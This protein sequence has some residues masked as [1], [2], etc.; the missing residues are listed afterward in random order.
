KTRAV[1][2]I[3]GDTIVVPVK[4][5]EKVSSNMELM[6]GLTSPRQSK[7]LEDAQ[8]GVPESRSP[9]RI[10]A[11]VTVAKAVR[12]RRARTGQRDE[13]LSADERTGK[14]PQVMSNGV[15]IENPA[16]NKIGSIGS[17]AVPVRIH[18]GQNAERLSRLVSHDPRE[19]KPTERRV[20]KM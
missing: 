17:L 15:H 8:I 19:L 5:V 4:R 3:D 6:P 9:K 14:R 18:A 20:G 12:Q 13:E 1:H 7:S 2:V 11:Q 10:F 16:G